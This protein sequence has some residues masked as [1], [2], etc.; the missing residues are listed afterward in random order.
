VPRSPKW[1]I[2]LLPWR[3]S[4]GL[5]ADGGDA[6]KGE[7][8]FLATCSSCHADNAKGLPGSG[9]DLT[10]TVSVARTKK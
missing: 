5:R 2:R 9:K 8:L 6:V 1:K 4:Q 7:T 10:R 3:R